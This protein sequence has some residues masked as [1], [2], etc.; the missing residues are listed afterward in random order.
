MKLAVKLAL[1]GA[2][3]VAG[4]ANAATVTNT[5][6][7]AGGSDLIL[8]VTDTTTNQFF[9]Q[10]LGNPLDSIY[11]KSQVIFDGA[12]SSPGSFRTPTA[13]AGSDA[14]LASFL[15]T[16][17]AGDEVIWSILASDN[18]KTT[19]QLGDQRALLTS[20]LDLSGTGT[21]F[22]NANVQTFS[23]KL[24]TLVN[25][26]NSTY[27][28]GNTSSSVGW[29]DSLNGRNAPLS[30]V[31]TLL[32]NGAPIGSS[33]QMYMFA[34]NG[35]GASSN[36]NIYLGGMVLIDA[37][38]NINVATPEGFVPLP[39]AV[40]LFGSGLLGLIGAGRR[41]TAVAA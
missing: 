32:G 34:T 18:T 6:K 25:Q 7:T 11:S 22:I 8:F 23:S 20:T 12:L 40:W 13:I 37:L 1:T 30:W 14:A 2:A 35:T 41:R 31:S 36:A 3:L 15:G 10:D 5:P 33:Q 21:T 39:A 9:T 24:N 26:V 4:V 38:G 27:A 17:H 16:T 29:G 28:N 19:N